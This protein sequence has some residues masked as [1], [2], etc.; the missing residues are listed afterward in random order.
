MTV[1][2]LERLQQQPAEEP[3]APLGST[4]K[5]KKTW[6][7]TQRKIKHSQGSKGFFL[8]DTKENSNFSVWGKAN[9]KTSETLDDMKS[10]RNRVLRSP[11]ICEL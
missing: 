8:C 11:K 9:A 5:T 6:H 3:N 7:K 2:Q 4:P 10:H 1:N